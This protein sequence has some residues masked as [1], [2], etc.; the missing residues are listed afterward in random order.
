MSI[1]A[2]T[3]VLGWSQER[4]EVFLTQARDDLKSRGCMLMELFTFVMGRSH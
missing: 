2:L 1:A 4:L 3:R